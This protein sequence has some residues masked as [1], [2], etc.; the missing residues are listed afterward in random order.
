MLFRS[1]VHK[2]NTFY[3]YFD[4]QAGPR[5]GY[6]SY[7]LG[8]WHMVVLNTNCSSVEG[9]CGPESQQVAWLS[10]DLANAGDRCVLAYGHHP[11]WSNGIAGPEPGI[12]ALFEVL[13]DNH[14]ALYLSGHEAH[15]ERYAPMNGLGRPDPTGTVQMVVGTGGQSVYTPALED[16]PWRQK[17]DPDRKSTRLNSSHSQ[18][19]RMPSS[20]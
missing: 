6:Y 7:D 14:V 4:G 19:S 3:E 11:R 10:E 5:S 8:A 15:Y 2:A 13:A 20:A 17:A 9:G 1:K 16:A 12:G 18:Q